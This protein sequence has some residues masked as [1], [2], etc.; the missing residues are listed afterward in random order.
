M[1]EFNTE[2]IRTLAVIEAMDKI[3]EINELT[4]INLN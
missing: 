1:P 2:L 3:I 4:L